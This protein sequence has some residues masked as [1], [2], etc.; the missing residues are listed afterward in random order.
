M[1]SENIKTSTFSAIKYLL[2]SAY[3]LPFFFLLVIFGALQLSP[4]QVQTLIKLEPIMSSPPGY[5]FAALTILSY[6]VKSFW[7]PLKEI[8][9]ATHDIKDLL[10]ANAIQQCEYQKSCSNWM[11]EHSAASNSHFEA[12]ES[13]L[14]ALEGFYKQ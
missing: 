12:M 13:K 3:G 10:S 8:K 14:G 1:S 5:A 9:C 11:Q 4:E 6:L 2:D 7:S